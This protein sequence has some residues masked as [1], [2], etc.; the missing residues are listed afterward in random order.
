[1]AT[2]TERL[3]TLEALGR[4]ILGR[5]ERVEDAL[6]GGGDV[7]YKRSVRGRL[8]TLE[9]TVAGFVLRR[10]FGAGLLHGWRSGVIVFC[11]VATAVA[12]WYAV[13]AH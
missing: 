9:T 11:A 8:H 12:S 10:N 1:M 13:L 4:E 7:E 3:A 6:N 5:V 2:V